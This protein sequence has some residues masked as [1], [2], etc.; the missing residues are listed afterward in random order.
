MG[1]TIPGSNPRDRAKRT[2]L[3][4]SDGFPVF[5]SCCRLRSSN[6]CSPVRYASSSMCERA[7]AMA[8]PDI[9]FLSQGGRDFQSPPAVEPYLV[10]H[11]TPAITRLVDVAFAFEMFDDVGG[12][13]GGDAPAGQFFFD[14]VRTSFGRG[15]KGCCPVEGF[16]GGEGFFS[17]GQM[18]LS[19]GRDESFAI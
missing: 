3:A 12:G 19:G 2:S 4:R 1:K 17:S 16:V 6:S 14:F 13:C 7:S 15:T 18:G 10:V 9:F 8:S 5:P 11:I